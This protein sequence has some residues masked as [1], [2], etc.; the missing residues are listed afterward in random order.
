[1]AKRDPSRRGAMSFGISLEGVEPLM[2]RIR[3]ELPEKM[4]T[5]VYKS[6][7][8]KAGTPLKNAVK[9]HA[10]R[11]GDTGALASSV[12]SSVRVFRRV[13]RG[14]DGKVFVSKSKLAGAASLWVGSDKSYTTTVLRK[15]EKKQRKAAPANYA[16]LVEFG[17]KRQKAKPFV[18]PAISEAGPRALDVLAKGLQVGLA[19]EAARL[20]KKAGK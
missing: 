16:H 3:D 5:R 9:K 17:T 2:K 20:K 12:K 18:R 8:A 1:M 7:V 10:R 6:A 14:S 11:V 4:R 15:G 13:G 19:R